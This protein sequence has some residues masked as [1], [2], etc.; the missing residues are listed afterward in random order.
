ML[1]EIYLIIKNSFS[2][3]NA[4]SYFYFLIMVHR[5]IVINFVLKERENTIPKSLNWKLNN[6]NR[7]ND[8]PSYVL[9]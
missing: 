8:I 3:I 5:W 9:S 1:R 6:D 2:H 7:V 4:I